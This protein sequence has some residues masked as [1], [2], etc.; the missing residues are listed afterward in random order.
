MRVDLICREVSGPDSLIYKFA[1]DDKRR[2]AIL[3]GEDDIATTL[4]MS[5]AIDEFQSEDR[6]SKPWLWP[7]SPLA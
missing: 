7:A 3:H 6:L 2:Q 5:A 1:M 4:R